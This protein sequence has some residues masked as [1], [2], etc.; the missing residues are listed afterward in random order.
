MATQMQLGQEHLPTSLCF[1]LGVLLSHGATKS[2]PPLLYQVQNVSTK[3]L[4]W[5]HVR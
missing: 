1:H 5:Q 4:Q 2:N 3:V